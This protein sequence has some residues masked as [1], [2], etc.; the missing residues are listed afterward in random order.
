MGRRLASLVLF[1]A[2]YVALASLGPLVAAAP[3]LASFVAA[4]LLLARE[5]EPTRISRG[6]P[7][8]P[9]GG[10]GRLSLR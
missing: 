2:G 8:A 4:S 7:A 3:A 10:D 5:R 1:V 6:E 9:G